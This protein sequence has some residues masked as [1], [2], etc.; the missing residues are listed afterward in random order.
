MKR[1]SGGQT[2]QVEEVECMAMGQEAC[3]FHILEEP[4]A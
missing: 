1:V 2:F 3:V 4:V